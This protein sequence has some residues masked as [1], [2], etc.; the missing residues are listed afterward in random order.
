MNHSHI[1]VQL[2]EEMNEATGPY[3][4]MTKLGYTNPKVSEAMLHRLDTYLKSIGKERDYV[5]EE[6]IYG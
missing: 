1:L 6:K 3:E 4:I 5:V 2:D